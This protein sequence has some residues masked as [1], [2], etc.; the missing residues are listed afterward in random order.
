MAGGQ[1]RRCIPQFPV[2]TVKMCRATAPSLR[3][4]CQTTRHSSGSP[5]PIREIPTSARPSSAAQ[6]FHAMVS[7]PPSWPIATGGKRSEQ[8]V[9]KDNS[10][11][12]TGGAGPV[13]SVQRRAA[14]PSSGDRVAHQRPSFEPRQQ[15]LASELARPRRQGP[16]GTQA[17]YPRGRVTPQGTSRFE[18]GIRRDRVPARRALSRRTPSS[19]RI[20]FAAHT[21]APHRPP[22]SRASARCPHGLAI[23]SSPRSPATNGPMRASGSSKS[24]CA[25]SARRANAKT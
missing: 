11:T 5:S 2:D 15:P 14:R 17:P 13:A 21:L 20:D 18:S 25:K 19:G 24:I 4:A 6:N 8:P 10:A 1:R 22:R 7:T 3:C 16:M 9:S 12:N 23:N